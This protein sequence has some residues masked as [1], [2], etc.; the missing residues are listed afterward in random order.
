MALID[1]IAE[2]AKVPEE[3]SELTAKV[4]MTSGEVAVTFT[5]ADLASGDVQSPVSVTIAKADLLA[6]MD[7][8]DGEPDA[9]QGASTAPAQEGK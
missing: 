7:M 9:T 6:A 4:D 3:F 1:V 5:P 8:E 2:L